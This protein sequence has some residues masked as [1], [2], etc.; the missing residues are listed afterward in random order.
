[1][2]ESLAAQVAVEDRVDA[3]SQPQHEVWRVGDLVI[4]DG[5]QRVTR[6]DQ[7]I[8]LPKLSFDLLLALV[9]QAPNVVSLDSLLT[10]VWP[11]LVVGPETVVQRVKM[12]RDALDDR[13]AEPRYIAAL[14]G[15]GYRL[16]AEV[17]RVDAREGP[18]LG[19]GASPDEASPALQPAT[20]TAPVAVPP[21]RRRVVILSAVAL[22]LIGGLA[23]WALQRGVLSKS[24][25]PDADDPALR[26]VAVLPFKNLSGDPSDSAVALGVP[27]VVLDRL[28]SVKGLTV[29][30]RDSAIRA[31]EDSTDPAEISRRLRAVFLVD[32]TVQRSGT[33]LRVSARLVDARSARTLWST[34]YDRPVQDLFAMQDD[35]ATQVATALDDRISG[36]R[37]PEP[38]AAPTRN[39]EAYLAWL[40]GRTLT[41]RYTAAKAE[42]AAVEFER[43]IALDPDFAVAHAALYDA[44]MQSAAIRFEDTDAARL[45]YRPLLERA[46]A[47]DPE[48]G[49]VMFAQATW[50]DLDDARREAIFREAM[51]RD[52]GNSRGLISFATFLN[53]SMGWETPAKVRGSGLFTKDLTQY[54]IP[55]MPKPLAEVRHAESIR[56]LE[57]AVEIDPLA[58]S[59]RFNLVD[60]SDPDREGYESGL[61]A[62]LAIDPDFYPGLQR[63]ARFRWMFHDSPSQGIALIER[64]IAAD[65]QNPFARQTAATLY[66]DIDDAAAAADVAAAT[67]LSLA[68]ATPGLALHAGD[69]RRAGVAAQRHESFHF[70]IF[71]AF[72]NAE[73]L[74]DMALR[75]HDYASAEDL[76]CKRYN[77]CKDRRDGPLPD[78]D[79]VALGNFRAW[80]LLAHL[81]LVQGN[82]V[83]A[84]EILEEV[85]AW[86]DADDKFGPVFNQR[87][88]AQALMLLGRRDEALR[89]LAAAFA[90]DRDHAE[91]WYTIKRDPIFA[92]VRETAEFR[93]LAADAQRHAARERAAVEELRRQGTI[94]RRPAT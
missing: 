16:V 29:V 81:Q 2:P 93:A 66:L 13:A 3:S 65:P 41:G 78:V 15:R 46:L 33:M 73:A 74:R 87:T 27:D 24:P 36:M 30:A 19:Q 35:I 8:E 14:R 40:R 79:G 62:L 69:W 32:G 11:G 64:A 77:A 48:S 70:E 10:S 5:Q 25:A 42:A 12:L 37:A 54:Q 51:R 89:S 6:G 43:A 34:R 67:P 9:R 38:A 85:I 86:I 17:A 21:S 68:A 31:G 84:K 76:F 56:L 44:R 47:L 50:D 45:R 91:W 94:P 71:E 53:T 72:G 22:V 57:R 61:E 90:V 7:V 23:L 18:R 26:T 1:M 75:T 88:R 28:T 55:P 83:W 52:P 59:A 82:T 92:E 80:P 60:Y 4:D 20:A 58:A 39:I 63:L 49:A